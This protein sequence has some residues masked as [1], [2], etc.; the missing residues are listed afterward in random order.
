MSDRNTTRIPCRE[1]KGE[2]DECLVEIHIP[3]DVLDECGV[4]DADDLSYEYI[5]SLLSINKIDPPERTCSDCGSGL[6]FPIDDDDFQEIDE[7]LD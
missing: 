3:N 2:E 5:D 6:T 4:E 7:K 1:C